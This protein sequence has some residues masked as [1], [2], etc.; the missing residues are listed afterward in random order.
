MCGA[1]GR[2]SDN[3]W[4]KLLMQRLNIAIETGNDYNIRPNATL[5]IA[6]GNQGEIRGV[7]ASWW[8]FQTRSEKG[9]TYDKRYKSFNTR[10]EKLFSNRKRDFGYHRCVIPASCF[11][12]WKG[13]RFKI[14]AVEGA[15][16]FGGLYKRW[17]LDSGESGSNGY[18]YSCSIITLPPHPKLSHIH[19]KSIPLMLLEEEITPWL[20]DSFH[21][22]NY[23]QKTLESRIRFDLAVTPVD[24]KSPD[25][26]IGP[27]QIIEADSN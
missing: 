3:P 5:P 14:E 26:S 6:I 25:L 27:T 18:H 13:E 10:K 8:L 20:D 24:K 4:V 22:L 9:Y 7:N 21:N 11:Y 16:A 17:P 2:V 23:W 1:I 15:I 12:E 19:D